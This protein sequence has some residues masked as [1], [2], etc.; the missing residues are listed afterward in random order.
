M[1]KNTPSVTRVVNVGMSTERTLTGGGSETTQ[2]ES[3]ASTRLTS[4]LS[5]AKN[6]ASTSKGA[7]GGGGPR[8]S[9]K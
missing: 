3:L 6:D 8:V 2:D 9:I 4:T 5:D 1:N 7:S